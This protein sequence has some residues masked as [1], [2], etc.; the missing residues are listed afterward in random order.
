MK[1][2]FG[3]AGK[4]GRSQAIAFGCW[5][6]LLNEVRYSGFS[7]PGLEAGQKEQQPRPVVR[8]SPIRT[9]ARNRV[10]HL[11][12]NSEKRRESFFGVFLSLIFSFPLGLVWSRLILLESIQMQ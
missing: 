4:N 5:P 2:F 12:I 7:V 8:S 10:D 6:L 9:K 11:T 3:A 1:F